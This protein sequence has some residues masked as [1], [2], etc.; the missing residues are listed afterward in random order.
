M[1]LAIRISTITNVSTGEAD[2]GPFPKNTLTCND[3]RRYAE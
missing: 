3:S 2:L 1:N